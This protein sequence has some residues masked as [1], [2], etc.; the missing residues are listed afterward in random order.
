MF[1]AI[2]D[3]VLLSANRTECEVEVVLVEKRIN[4]VYCA[5]F[6]RNLWKPKI[7]SDLLSILNQNNY[8]VAVSKKV[9]IRLRNLIPSTDYELFCMTS[10][11]DGNVMPLELVL[12]TNISFTTIC[13]KYVEVSVLTNVIVANASTES[14]L[15][16]TLSYTP[17]SFLSVRVM[18]RNLENIESRMMNVY[19]SFIS[20]SNSSAENLVYKMSLFPTTIG[21]FQVVA[22]LFGESSKEYRIETLACLPSKLFVPTSS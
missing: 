13:C 6:P 2:D 1:N 11:L 22:L 9:R 7:N 14:A 20:I 18:L 3:V 5:A 12:A 16:M 17:S 10:S 19:P 15:L 4:Q 21:T 8:A